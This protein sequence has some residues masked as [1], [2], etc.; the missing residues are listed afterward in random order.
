[1]PDPERSGLTRRVLEEGPV[2]DP[3]AA[4]A[5]IIGLTR[6]REAIREEFEGLLRRSGELR[7]EGEGR[8]TAPAE[9]TRP[10]AVSGVMTRVRRW[11]R[12]GFDGGAKVSR[13][14][15]MSRA[16]WSS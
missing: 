13:E 1:M 14:V 16:W 9:R 5:T 11:L 3:A 8:V 2:D 15:S 12:A 6:L 4:M 10:E 7:T